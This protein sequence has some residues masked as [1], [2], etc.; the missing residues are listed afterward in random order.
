MK[1][2][3]IVPHSTTNLL[4]FSKWV[5]EAAEFDFPNY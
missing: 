1:R 3:K 5:H 2:V 4:D